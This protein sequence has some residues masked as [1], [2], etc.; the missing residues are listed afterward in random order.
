MPRKKSSHHLPPESAALRKLRERNGLTMDEMASRLGLKVATYISYEYGLRKKIPEK[1]NEAARMLTIDPEYSYIA[2]LYADRPMRD[3]A[4]E[5]ARRMGVDENSP[6][7]IAAAIAVNKSTVSRWLNAEGETRLSPQE[8]ITYERRVER[9]EA[10]RKAVEKR[11]Q[12]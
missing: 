6:S 2:A 3:I 11:R 10:Y 7:E 8:L 4:Q 5:W 9:E 12:A 1:V